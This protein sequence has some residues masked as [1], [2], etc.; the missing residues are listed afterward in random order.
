[1]LRHFVISW[2]S[3]RSLDSTKHPYAFTTSLNFELLSPVTFNE[4]GDISSSIW[5]RIKVWLASLILSLLVSFGQ[6]WK[7]LISLAVAFS[8]VT[9]R[10]WKVEAN[11]N[12]A[13][14]KRIVSKT[15]TQARKAFRVNMGTYKNTN[16]ILKTMAW[17]T[18]YFPY[19]IGIFSLHLLLFLFW[20]NFENRC[21]LAWG[22]A[23]ASCLCCC[24]HSRK[25]KL[26]V[27]SH[28]LSR[29][30]PPCFDHVL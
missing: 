24:F 20:D 18:K 30:F 27:F 7:K 2:P 25:R 10:S 23:Q 14:D 3:L 22:R 19:I 26:A 21:F 6:A 9:Q 5:K 4:V 16:L 12:T 11:Q 28:L 29:H 8:M 15:K 1:M 13:F 17:M